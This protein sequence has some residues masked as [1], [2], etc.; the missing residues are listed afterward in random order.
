M[1]LRPF[2]HIC[3]TVL[4][5]ASAYAASTNLLR[6]DVEDA[7][8]GASVVLN[9]DNFTSIG[10]LL[11]VPDTSVPAGG[12]PSQLYYGQAVLVLS[13]IDQQYPI[14]AGIACY[15]GNE[16]GCQLVYQ[17]PPSVEAT[18]VPSFPISADDVIILTVTVVDNTTVT[19]NFFDYTTDQTVNERL[20]SPDAQPAPY[21]QAAWALQAQAPANGPYISFGSIEWETSTA[22]TATGATVGPASGTT[23]ADSALA[24]VSVTDTSITITQT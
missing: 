18:A 22:N 11:T 4:C 3:V 14:A 16:N 15:A 13:D 6:R 5:C 1:S 19:I 7:Q 20:V 12:D 21:V 17:Y 23:S 9:N 24:T 10:G 8:A 2:W